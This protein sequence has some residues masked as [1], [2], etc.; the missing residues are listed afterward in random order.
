MGASVGS[1]ADAKAEQKRQATAYRY[2]GDRTTRANK[3]VKSN[4]EQEESYGQEDNVTYEYGE[5]QEGDDRIYD[6][7]I[8][9]PEE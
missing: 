8:P 9:G 4:S 6:M 7:G 2:Q 3:K 1:A 5:S